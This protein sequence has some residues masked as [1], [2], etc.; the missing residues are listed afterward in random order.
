[1]SQPKTG[2]LEIVVSMMYGGKSSYLI[3]LIETLGYACKILYINHSLDTRDTE[4]YSTHSITLNK[5]LSKK[6]NAT[7]IKVDKLANVPEELLKT[8]PVVCIDECQFFEDLAVMVKYMV[9]GLGLRVYAASL[10]GDFK[11]KP[12]GQIGDLLPLMDDIVHL[13]DTQCSVCA[14]KKI[15]TP[16]LFT[17]RI[18]DQNSSQIEI[19]ASNYMPVC[20]GCYNELEKQRF[21]SYISKLR[22]LVSGVCSTHPPEDDVNGT[23]EY[24][25]VMRS[26]V[27]TLVTFGRY[28]KQITSLSEIKDPEFI[29]IVDQIDD[30]C[31][32]LSSVESSIERVLS[33][34]V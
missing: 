33:S 23:S 13:K 26:A 3:H 20:R 6:L 28:E 34:Q 1:M 8:H 5:S 24:S 12:F 11:R 25:K 32:S 15:L 27:H 21:L 30:V 29:E 7:M 17:W 9:D 19:G 16:S 4:P 18:N 22:D 14:M 10:N 2:Y 31:K